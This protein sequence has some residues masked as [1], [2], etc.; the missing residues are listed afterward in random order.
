M[1][2][3]LGQASAF[4]SR[5]FANLIFLVCIRMMA[6]RRLGRPHYEGGYSRRGLFLDLSDCVKDTP[7]HLYSEVP[8]TRGFLP[9]ARGDPIA[10]VALQSTPT[11]QAH[12]ITGKHTPVLTNTFHPWRAHFI[13]GTQTSSL[14]NTLRYWQTHFIPGERILS[15]T[16]TLR[17]WQAHFILGTSIIIGEHT[18][19]LAITF[20]YRRAHLITGEP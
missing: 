3:G 18:S 12:F 13:I 15:L 17:H 20:H 19:L 16:N 5:T 1:S 11:L 4:S 2:F 6:K 10:A 14:A 7:S 9:G 8:A